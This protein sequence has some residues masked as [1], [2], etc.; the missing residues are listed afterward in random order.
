MLQKLTALV[1]DNTVGAAERYIAAPE[2]P[3]GEA[4]VAWHKVLCERL[5]REAQRGKT[6]AEVVFAT[7]TFHANGKDGTV[8]LPS[9]A[10]NEKLCDDFERFCTYTL[11]AEKTFGRTDSKSICKWCN[12]SLVSRELV[13]NRYNNG[14]HVTDAL[15]DANPPWSFNIR[16]CDSNACLDLAYAN[17]A[18]W[19]TTALTERE[20]R[21][22]IVDGDKWFVS[23]HC[24]PGLA[25]WLYIHAQDD[26]ACDLPSEAAMQ[27]A[28]TRFGKLLQAYAQR[29]VSAWP[30]LNVNVTFCRERKP[31][32]SDDTNTVLHV[33]HGLFFDWSSPVADASEPTVS[34]AKK[35]KTSE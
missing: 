35:C 12:E 11:C 1:R 3:T 24:P 14:K 15:F 32:V 13:Q 2:F 20:F 17:A 5:E 22:E 34:A 30:D 27:L 26:F 7:T 29:L 9:I 8:A 21:I 31:T 23:P 16:L 25:E 28:Y 19:F 6:T 4:L 33:S 18:Q 10:Y